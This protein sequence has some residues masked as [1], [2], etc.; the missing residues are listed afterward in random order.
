MKSQIC[1]AAALLLGMAGVARADAK[2]E[3][4]AAAQKLAD[5][6]NYSWTKSVKNIAE[7]G[8]EYGGGE[9]DYGGG[10]IHG[11]TEKGGLTAIE[12]IWPNETYEVVVGTN[13][14]VLKHGFVWQGC[15]ELL[16]PFGR[17]GGGAGQRFNP[18]DFVMVNLDTRTPAKL[19]LELVEK[20]V[21]LQKLGNAFSGALPEESAEGML[22]FRVSEL[23]SSEQMPQVINSTGSASFFLSDGVL[24]T[25]EFHLAGTM[26]FEGTHKIDRIIKIEISDIGKTKLDV[27]DDAKEELAA[28]EK[29]FGTK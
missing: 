21:D 29:K 23:P 28:L 25:I 5:S 19:A 13:Y 16:P 3:V 12:I 17:E 11:K 18:E 7:E 1:F 2:D 24:S 6:A 4:R 20:T 22:K 14:S 9:G 26:I 10:T 15:R 8:R 27:P